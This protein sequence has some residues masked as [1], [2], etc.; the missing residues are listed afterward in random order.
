MIMQPD[1]VTDEWFVSALEQTRQKKN[2]AALNKI[3]LESLHEGKAVQVMHIG[4]F[5]NRRAKF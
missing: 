1:N 4:P 5:H 3:R 2:L